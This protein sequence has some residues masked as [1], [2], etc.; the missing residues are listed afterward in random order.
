M[1]LLFKYIFVMSYLQLNLSQTRLKSSV[2][3]F[4]FVITLGLVKFVFIALSLGE[5]SSLYSWMF[6]RIHTFYINLQ[7]WGRLV[8]KWSTTVTQLCI[9]CKSFC[10]MQI[11]L[12]L[13]FKRIGWESL[14]L[15]GV[16]FK[17]NC[18]FHVKL[19]LTDKTDF[20]L[21][22]HCLFVSCWSVLIDQNWT[23]IQ[24]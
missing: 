2:S 22:A 1:I 19:Y 15:R 24:Q 13:C 9:F 21:L 10:K 7:I 18:F 12:Y 4:L 8:R 20:T 11:Y 17:K 23:V 5:S 16:V 14:H 3:P 6:L